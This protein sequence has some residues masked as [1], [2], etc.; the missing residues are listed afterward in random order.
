L[1]RSLVRD[2]I[3]IG[4]LIVLG[5]KL[6]CLCLVTVLVVVIEEGA[7]CHLLL[8]VRSAVSLVLLCHSHA[9]HFTYYLLLLSRVSSFLLFPFHRVP[10][11]CLGGLGSSLFAF[12]IRGIC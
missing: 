2:V 4:G 10:A 6:A 8:G 11:R 7:D 3:V 5:I 9:V 1:L 12:N